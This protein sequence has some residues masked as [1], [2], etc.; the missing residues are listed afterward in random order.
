MNDSSGRLPP[1]PPNFL[2][3][4]AALLRRAEQH[5]AVEKEVIAAVR[6]RGA[7]VPREERRLLLEEELQRR[8]VTRD[9][10]WIEQKLDGLE[11]SGPHRAARIGNAI[12]NLSELASSMQRS[13]KGAHA[14]PEWMRPPPMPKQTCLRP[15][16]EHG[17]SRKD[18]R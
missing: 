17:P 9:A 1:E 2:A 16:S 11:T 6:S 14:M 4:S 15:L 7:D 12:L 13:E 10:V 18:P 3:L 5:A 8:N